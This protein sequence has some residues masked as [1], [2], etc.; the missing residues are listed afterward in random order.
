MKRYPALG[1][2]LDESWAGCGVSKRL[3]DLSHRRGE[4]VLEIN[5]GFVRPEALLQLLAR[6]DPAGALH[7]GLEHLE[8]L[9]LQPNL[10]AA[11]AQL[12]T[13]KIQLEDTKARRG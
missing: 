9:L 13:D 4:P 10:Y 12:A 3:P 11:L 5:E 6:N 8:R 7:H 1:E 2:C